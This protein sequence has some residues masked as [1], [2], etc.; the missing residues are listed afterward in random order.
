MCLSQTAQRMGLDNTPDEPAVHNLQMLCAVLEQVRLK[1]GGYPI[2]ISSGYRSP[3]VNVACGGSSTS[4][5]MSGLAAD[6]TCPQFGTP[7]DI[8][9]K[10]EPDMAAL[11]IDQL[12]WEWSGW[13]HL[14][15]TQG[16]PRC[17]AMTINESG[18]T[19]G[20]A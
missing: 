1:L 19:T 12:I 2:L 11:K 18:T 20:F 15:L 16:D 13:V 8:C 10:L 6:F 14:G 4:A 7:L 5:H 3:E 9:V 17:M